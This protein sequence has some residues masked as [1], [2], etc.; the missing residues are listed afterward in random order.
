MNVVLKRTQ[1]ENFHWAVCHLQG[2]FG[3]IVAGMVI[4]SFQMSTG[5]F[6]VD[7]GRPAGLKRRSQV[8]GTNTGRCATDK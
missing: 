5:F 3:N 4:S 7:N 6:A 8:T 2:K 1:I